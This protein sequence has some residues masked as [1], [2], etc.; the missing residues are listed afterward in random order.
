[1]MMKKPI[2]VHV[3]SEDYG[4]TNVSRELSFLLLVHLDDINSSLIAAPTVE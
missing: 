2:E 1:M 4:A 3:F